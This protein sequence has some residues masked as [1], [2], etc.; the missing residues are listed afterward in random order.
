MEESIF[1]EMKKEVEMFM[2]VCVWLQASCDIFYI[3]NWVG[4]ILC[5]SK[6]TELG[7][8]NSKVLDSLMV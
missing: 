8:L 7:I 2:C 1:E 3:T 5:L 4:V 6:H